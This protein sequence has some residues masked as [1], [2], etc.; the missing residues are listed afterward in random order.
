MVKLEWT[1]LDPILQPF[2]I[3]VKPAFL[4]NIIFSIDVSIFSVARLNIELNTSTF[5]RKLTTK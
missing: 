5:F 2:Y 1:I 3:I 4:R